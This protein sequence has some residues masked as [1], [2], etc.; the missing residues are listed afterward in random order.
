[1]E[2]T[3]KDLVDAR[4]H[5]LEIYEN[6]MSLGQMEQE[7]AELTSTSLMSTE[8]EGEYTLREL[9]K[10]WASGQYPFHLQRHGK[11]L[12][13]QTRPSF[14]Q[15]AFHVCFR[16]ELGVQKSSHRQQR[17]KWR[18]MTSKQDMV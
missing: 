13:V 3:R 10:H 2:K 18:S 4:V 11:P 5:I 8:V 9:R 7:I 1:M 15:R 14:F 17:T 12:Q 6:E 16:G